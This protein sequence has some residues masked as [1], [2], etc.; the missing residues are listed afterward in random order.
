MITVP[1][2][3]HAI[4]LAREDACLE[5]FSPDG[6]TLV[7]F[8]AARPLS[9]SP[10]LGAPL[11]GAPAKSLKLAISIWDVE[12]GRLQYK[13]EEQV[14][15]V[16]GT[17]F[18]PDRK[19]LLLTDRQ[20]PP[21]GLRLW[22]LETGLSAT[23]LRSEKSLQRA[24]PT[25]FTPDGRCLIFDTEDLAP[26]G[27]V[28]RGCIIWDIKNHCARSTLPKNVVNLTVAQDGMTYAFYAREQ[29]G[30]VGSV[31]LWSLGNNKA[32]AIRMTEHSVCAD[33]VAFSPQLSSFASIEH[34]NGRARPAEMRLRDTATGEIRSSA[35]YLLGEECKPC[36]SFSADGK[37]LICRNIGPQSAAERGTTIWDVDSGLRSRNTISHD[38]SVSRDGRWYASVDDMHVAVFD[39][40]SS[41]EH[42]SLHIPDD[43]LRDLGVSNEAF[44]PD[45]PSV[46]F[47]PDGKT[48]CVT[49]L[50]SEPQAFTLRASSLIHVGSGTRSPSRDTMR[51]W[52]IESGKE[53]LVRPNCRNVLFSPDGQRFAALDYDGV[54]RIWDIPPT[55]PLAPCLL[56]A[57]IL[58]G[59]I[60]LIVLTAQLLLGRRTQSTGHSEAN[61]A[62]HGGH[63]KLFCVRHTHRPK[64]SVRSVSHDGRSC[65]RNATPGC[66]GPLNAYICHISY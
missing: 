34:P 56:L 12:T 15:G 46:T 53:M 11:G 24:F 32:P 4:M 50:R 58:W 21:D 51:L 33:T 42:V 49:E 65:R 57:A 20:A 62:V 37:R 52:E 55:R 22:D 61:G 3:P 7:T 16:F 41:R 64:G 29:D 10:D 40:L 6:K 30:K 60:V 54:I 2:Q 45:G 5:S 23:D 31:Q 1:P 36:L 48:L 44:L 35:T 19:L 28:Q 18:S 14:F 59:A 47:S 38:Q 63:Q 43:G 66:A 39:A 13:Y 17:L 26:E 9:S 27:G 25:D 8:C